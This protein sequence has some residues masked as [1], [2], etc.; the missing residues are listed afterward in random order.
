M[1]P[2]KIPPE[3]RQSA[4]VWA[5]ALPASHNPHITQ[6]PPT[7]PFC[8]TQSSISGGGIVLIPG[9]GSSPRPRVIVS[10]KGGFHAAVIHF[11]DSGVLRPGDRRLNSRRRYSC[12]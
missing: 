5:Q 6:N 12:L 1:E 8:S 2:D 11:N 7:L 3:T 10:N 9:G 4:A